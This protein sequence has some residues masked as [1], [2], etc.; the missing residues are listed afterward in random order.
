MKNRNFPESIKAFNNALALYE[1]EKKWNRVAS[2][3]NKISENHWRN[4][5]AK[6]S[7]QNAKKALD[8]SNA[9]LKKDNQE[10]AFAYDN[11]GIYYENSS[12]YDDALSYYKKALTIRQKLFSKNHP[13]LAIS[14]SNLGIINL[15]TS[16]YYEALQ[17]F[18][19]A[20]V[21]TLE[22]LGQDHLKT[23]GIYSNMGNCFYGLGKFDKSIE[24]FKKYSEIIAK[25]FGE[26][27][28]N[29]GIVYTN[30]G[31]TYNTINQFSNSEYFYKKALSI[32]IE[33]KYT[34]GISN[35]YTNLGNLYQENGEY[36]KSIIY[37]KKGLAIGLEVYG[38][39]HPNVGKAYNN[40]GNSYSFKEENKEALKYYDKALKIYK[41][42]FGENHKSIATTYN[43]LGILYAR[44]KKYDTALNYYEEAIR[45]LKNFVNQD[46]P[47]I[48]FYNNNIAD[49]Y[50]KMGQPE[51][52]LLYFKKGL[53]MV[54]N[55]YGKKHLLT[56]S[57]YIKIAKVYNQ[58]EK[59]ENAI[60]YF[61]K[62]LTTNNKNQNIKNFD[63]TFNVSENYNP[64]L[65][66]ETVQGK[67][68]TFQLKFL[69]N[70]ILKE[71]E[72]S[73]SLFKEADILI[74]NIRQSYK[75]HKDKLSF[76][77]QTKETYYN[78]IKTHL[79]KHQET[80]KQ[81][82]LEKVFYYIERSK[83]NI[84]KELLD[85]NFSKNFSGIPKELLVLEKKLKTNR[86]FY[87]SQII[88]NNSKTSI[89]SLKIKEYEN[90]LFAID[91]KQDSL[92][93]KL[94]T[95]YPQ[96]YQLKHKNELMSLSEIQKKLDNESTLLEFFTADVNTYVVIISKRNVSAKKLVTP[97]LD[98]NIQLLRQSITNKNTA[99]YK[100]FASALY[101]ELITPIKDQIIG[102]N[103]IIVPDGPLWHLNFDLLLTENVDSNNPKQLSYFLNDYAINYANSANLLFNSFKSDQK[104]EKKEECL[105][106]SFTDS[107][108]IVNSKAIS[109]ATLRGSVDDLPGTRKEIKAISNIVKGQYYYGS[110]AIEANF[111]KN[112]GKYNILHLAL[113]GEVDNEHPEK[114]KL[115]FTK[116]KDTLEDNLL[117]SHEL[118]AIDIPAELTV[119]SA[120]NTGTGK[121]AKG[122]G[123]MSLGNAFQY[124][125]TKSLLLTSWAV[126]DQTTPEL[127]K[128]FYSNLKKG[129][130][131][132]KALQQA[133][134]QYLNNA[135]V[136]RTN[137]FYWGGFYLLGNSNAIDFSD[138]N[139]SYIIFG[140]VGLGI[141]LLSLFWYKQ[142]TKN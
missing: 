61:D 105:A 51:N 76:A 89:D 40:I 39:T 64:S 21:I 138:N 30:L 55:R 5:N 34:T 8:I 140:L 91:T 27:H 134:L 48:A 38:E 130:N 57:Y 123:I 58:L 114:S 31:A 33:N 82:S 86:A 77:K 137:P 59:Y 9:Y 99:N 107:S 129:M 104:S 118:F 116:S 43:N 66:L 37:H 28:F 97:K 13:D 112:V 142:K 128:Y 98:K 96:Y 84:L 81:E 44:E 4:N 74:N 12:R 117:Y 45:I 109:L 88:N 122:E 35:L 36:D 101:K 60:A 22:T 42:V 70:N 120:C 53:N 115:F 54:Q 100:K 10:E 106:F 15:T 20:L 113:H 87:T 95:E 121:I 127:M 102:D 32:F 29:M 126:S 141:I 79:L 131:K 67:A 1:K 63:N 47:Q 56:T 2:C 25:N 103:L 16:K 50:A 23:G 80:Q 73:A 71:L 110:E 24:Y 17:N 6:N 111:K 62:A 132:S 3:Y 83:S 19:R 26:N 49:L 85:D 72:R 139:F 7:L 52:A 11:I 68:K 93:K 125:G 90:Q 65:L 41:T 75:N 92:I 136:N 78:A 135:A 108:N 18:E 133:K 69:E 46:H 94:K 119:L 14:Y 124:A